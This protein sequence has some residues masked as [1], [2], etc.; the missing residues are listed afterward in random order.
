MMNR[1]VA[2]VLLFALIG[3]NFSRFFVFAG[4]SI[5]QKY[6]AAALCENKNKPW[7]HCNGK[8]YLMKKIKQVEE[9]QRNEDRQTQKNLFQETFIGTGSS[10]NFYSGPVAVIATPYVIGRF[11]APVRTIF[12]PPS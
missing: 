3:S 5:N 7:M 9:K 4:F 6:I 12:Q 1:A 8:C 2:I 11:D 10:I